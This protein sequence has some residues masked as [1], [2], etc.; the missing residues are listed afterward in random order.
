MIFRVLSTLIWF[1]VLAG[2]VDPEAP[3]WFQW[4]S[5]MAMLGMIA[6]CIFALYAEKISAWAERKEAELKSRSKR[7]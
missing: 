6:V 2:I 4:I 3:A 1:V 7:K 5:W